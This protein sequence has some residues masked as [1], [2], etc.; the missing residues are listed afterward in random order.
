MEGK[1]DGNYYVNT[2]D[3]L[4]HSFALKTGPY[5]LQYLY[6]NQYINTSVVDLTTTEVPT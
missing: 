6:Q 2:T 3:I 1:E 4:F 5:F